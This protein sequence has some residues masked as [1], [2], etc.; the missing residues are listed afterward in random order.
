ML[1][2]MMLVMPIVVMVAL[3]VVIVESWKPGKR[4]ACLLLAVLILLGAV[5]HFL[6]GN[7]AL[8]NLEWR[9]IDKPDGSR[10]W[11]LRQPVKKES[12]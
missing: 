3:I 7:M 9:L 2:M 10:Q 4:F 8:R 6:L 12:L 1:M 5:S 11:E